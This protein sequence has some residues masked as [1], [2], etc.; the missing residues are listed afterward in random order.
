MPTGS[1][2]TRNMTKVSRSDVGRHQPEI[3]NGMQRHREQRAAEGGV[4][5]IAPA[6]GA[7]Q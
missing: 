3:D 2:K 4:D 5:Q 1:E 6:E 7:R